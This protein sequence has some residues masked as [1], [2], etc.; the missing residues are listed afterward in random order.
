M[1]RGGREDQVER[2]SHSPT[3][4]LGQE[5]CNISCEQQAPCWLAPPLDDLSLF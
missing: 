4:D 1:D 2:L 3:Y 5:G